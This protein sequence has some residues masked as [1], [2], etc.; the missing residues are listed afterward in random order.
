MTSDA[1]ARLVDALPCAETASA[2]PD[3]AMFTEGPRSRKLELASDGCDS[4]R[5]M[6]VARPLFVC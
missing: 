4:W 6:G 1:E 5:D 3:D 2:T